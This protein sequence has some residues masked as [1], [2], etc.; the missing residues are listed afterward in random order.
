MEQKFK[1]TS[2]TVDENLCTACGTCIDACPMMILE[3][4]DDCCVLADPIR[5]LE[6][7]TC[8]RG[9]SEK[10]I[11]IQFRDA[12]ETPRTKPVSITPGKGKDV[13]PPS[14]PGYTPV[15]ATLF[16]MVTKELQLSQL[17]TLHG[18]DLSYLD[19]FELEGEHCFF[20]AYQA[21]KL[22]KIGVSS[23]DFYGAM[24]AEVLTI[25]PGPEYDMPY[26]IMDWDESEEHIFFICDLMPSDDAGRNNAYLQK[27]GF[28]PLEEMYE[29]YS[30]IPGLNPS[31]F[32]WVR[33]I[34]SPYIITGNIDKRSKENVQLIYDCAVEYLRAW[35]E[36]YRGAKPHDPNSMH[37]KLV[38]ARR[39]NIRTLYGENDP[40][41]AVIQKFLGAELAEVASTIIEP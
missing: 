12:E 37:M 13:I 6:C 26:Y 34:H 38:K 30:A 25:T 41:G 9:C 35:L 23:M 8:V 10:A 2:L 19:N 16:D 18:T 15:L 39:R 24:R 29:K 36:I 28:E 11:T 27:Y 7:E 31:A 14:P 40:G 5:C 1:E 3:L 21:D 33:A 4:V 22:E 20:R 17:L 32:H